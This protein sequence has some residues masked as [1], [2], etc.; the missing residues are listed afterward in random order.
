MRLPQRETLYQ[1][2]IVIICATALYQVNKYKSVYPQ[3]D[4]NP[5]NSFDTSAIFQPETGQNTLVT[6][7]GPNDCSSCLGIIDIVDSLSIMYDQHYLRIMY[8][9][10]AEISNSFQKKLSNND[11]YEIINLAN[12]KISIPNN[13]VTPVILLYDKR[14][15]LRYIHPPSP[16]VVD[17]QLLLRLVD[18]II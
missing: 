5:S 14:G 13:S 4:V 11:R 10:N 12:S 7:I 3:N 18:I 17:Q 15:Q 2:A 6:L 1:I 9:Y 8:L 16:H